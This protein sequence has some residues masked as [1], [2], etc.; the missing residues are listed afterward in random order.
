MSGVTL[1][2]YETLETCPHCGKPL[3]IL[4]DAFCPECREPLDETP[5]KEANSGEE[6]GRNQFHPGPLLLLLA[7]MAGMFS[8]IHLFTRGYWL[9]GLYTGGG[10]VALVILGSWFSSG[11]SQD[12]HA[13]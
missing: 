13:G 6:S 7:G 11:R 12:P 4:V 9:D 1:V 3:P 10:S 5:A 8:G 2:K